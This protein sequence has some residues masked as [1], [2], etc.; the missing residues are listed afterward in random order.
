MNHELSI[1]GV[2]RCCVETFNR[3]H[4]EELDTMEYYHCIY[5]GSKMQ[6]VVET[7]GSAL[8]E[9]VLEISTN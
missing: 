2:F 1:G 7:E 9:P 4:E 8:W 6:K 3:L 5:C